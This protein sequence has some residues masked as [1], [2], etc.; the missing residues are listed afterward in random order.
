MAPRLDEPERVTSWLAG[1][2]DYVFALTLMVSRWLRLPTFQTAPSRTLVIAEGPGA[3]RD[4]APRWNEHERKS[5][6][7]AF[8]RFAEIGMVIVSFFLGAQLLSGTPTV[9]APDLSK[10]I[11]TPDNH[12]VESRAIP[13]ASAKQI[14]VPAEQTITVVPPTVEATVKAAEEEEIAALAPLPNEEASAASA[15][16]VTPV[17]TVE[18]VAPTPEPTTSDATLPAPTPPAPPAATEA[19]SRVNPDLPDRY[20]TSDEIAAAA[21]AAGWP[22]DVI[23]DLQKVAW[24]ESRYHTHAQYLG[25]RGLMQVLPFWFEAAGLD[26][27]MWAD[28]VTNLKAAKVVYDSHMADFGDPWSAWTC[29]P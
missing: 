27:S 24:C 29:K 1:W 13:S 11:L 10:L 6:T 28:P 9:A 12:G 21:L 25:A 23:P 7:N 20:L 16:A 22:A 14:L 3:E 18:A 5:S 17:A 19:P 2:V 8:V 15:P 26:L 4:H